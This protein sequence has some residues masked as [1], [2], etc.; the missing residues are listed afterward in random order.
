MVRRI[1]PV[2]GAI[3]D[4]ARLPGDN[5]I[6]DGMAVGAD[7]LLYVTTV[8]GGGIDV[9]RPDG[10]FERHLK[11]GTVPTNCVFTGRDLIMTDAGIPADSADASY[12]GQLWRLAIDAEGLG[13]W[14]GSIG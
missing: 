6:A 13:T 8:N 12:G 5:P 10:T 4:I 1:D 3:E 9:I 14:Y 2:S 11:A 7:G